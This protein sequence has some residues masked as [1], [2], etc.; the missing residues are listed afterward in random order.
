M[1]SL[2]CRIPLIAETG[3]VLVP[4]SQCRWHTQQEFMTR[5]KVVFEAPLPDEHYI[6][7]DVGDLLVFNAQMIHSGHYNN[8][9]ERKALDL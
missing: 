9:T 2:H 7:L 3:L 1:L 8:T 5:S 4:G 6:G